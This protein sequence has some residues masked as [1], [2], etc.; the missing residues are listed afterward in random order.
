MRTPAHWLRSCEAQ[1]LANDTFQL[2]GRTDSE[3]LRNWLDRISPADA[4]DLFEWGVDPEGPFRYCGSF[5]AHDGFDQLLDSGEVE[6][7]KE[8][9]LPYIKEN[10]PDP[11]GYEGE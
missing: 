9:L 4:L 7:V 3:I 2:E 6:L 5:D 8:A 11:D 1:K 10:T